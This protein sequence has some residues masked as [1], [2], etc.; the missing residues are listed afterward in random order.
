MKIRGVVVA[1]VLVLVITAMFSG[2]GKIEEEIPLS[3]LPSLEELED[4]LRLNDVSERPGAQFNQEIWNKAQEIKEAAAKD[5]YRISPH[6]VK[7]NDLYSVYCEAI[8]D[9]ETWYWDPETDDL[10]QDVE[11]AKVKWLPLEPKD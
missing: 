5:G 1:L 10:Y 7:E 11:L 8:V 2:C 4:W 6:W 3:N 9:G